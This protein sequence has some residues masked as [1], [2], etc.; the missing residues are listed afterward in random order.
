MAVSPAKRK[1]I[2]KYDSEH[3]ERLNLQLRKGVKQRYKD[4]AESLNLSVAML[5]QNAVEEYIAKNQVKK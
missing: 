5:I 1:A 4:I 2:K 3:Y